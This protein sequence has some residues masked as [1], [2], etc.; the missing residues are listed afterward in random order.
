MKRETSEL[1]KKKPQA[2]QP[3]WIRPSL[4]RRH[5][6][7]VLG[8]GVTG[9]ALGQMVRPM[10]VL[11]D[12]PVVPLDRAKN[13]IFI[14]L[15]GAPSPVDTFDLKEGP[16]T[17]ASFN[18][19]SYGDIRFPQGLLPQLA[20][21]LGDFAIIRSMRAWALV[22]SLAQSWIQIGRSPASALG[23][24]APHIGSVVALEKAAERTPEDILPGFI[25]LNAGGNQAGAGYFP[26]EYAPFEVRP[27]GAGLRNTLHPDG[28]Q[29]WQ[30]RWELLHQMD[31]PLRQNSPLG[32]L[33]EDMDVFYDAGQRL[34]YNDAVQSAFSF[35]DEER[36]GFGGSSFGDACLVA[37]NVLQADLGTRFVQITSGGWDHHANIYTA[38]PTLAPSLDQ[39][40]AGL[41]DSL[42][43]TGQL[44]QTLVVVAGE[45]GRTVGALNNQAGRDH[46]LQQFALFAGAGVRGGNV[47]GSTDP[48]GAFTSDPG[49]SRGRDIRSEDIEAT[50]YSA[51][52]INWTTVR[53]DDPLGRGFEYT[54]FAESDIYAPINELWG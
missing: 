38:L 10:E 45:F 14:L 6:F 52:G 41:L 23:S 54:P 1:L 47:I 44:D 9:Y 17:P 20:D 34:M 16:W 13:C 21:R 2:H 25:A 7:Q 18:P 39:G 29:R 27:S 8:T 12:L 48:T 22:H 28:K 51:M 36:A 11:A 33:A 31:D 49:W 19:T 46:Y 24:I 53:Y 15:A 4:T 32:A 40:L 37:K 26:T 43:Q 50:I 3:F 30:G 35:S 5:F 42:Q